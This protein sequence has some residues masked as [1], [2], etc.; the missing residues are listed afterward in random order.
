[1]GIQKVQNQIFKC[2]VCGNLIEILHGATGILFCCGEAMDLLDSNT[3]DAS[4]DKHKPI[5]ISNGENSIVKIGTVPHPM[6]P[7]HFI[8]W[9]EIINKSY[10]NR[11]FLNAGMLPE[12][13]F[14]V[15]KQIGMKVRAYCNKHGLWESDY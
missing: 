6:E 5:L 9:V 12:A 11:K 1:M 3:I 14:Y 10:L 15:H 7:D 8:E 13:E 2:N 4:V